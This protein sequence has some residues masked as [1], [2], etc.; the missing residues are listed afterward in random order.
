MLI[1]ISLFLWDFIL[2]ALLDQWFLCSL[3]SYYIFLHLYDAGHWG[4]PRLMLPLFFLLIQDY[5]LFGRVGLVCLYLL[6]IIFVCR[7]LRIVVMH[8]WL[9][10]IH[11][12]MIITLF[13]SEFLF[14][15]KWLF[16][17]SSGWNSTIVKISLTLA[18]TP[19]LYVVS[20]R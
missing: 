12:L 3:C 9:P 18:M 13:V 1:S 11:I 17:S 6:P 4:N 16:M 14:V 8:R 5:F 10:I 20:K 15:K 2:Y 7:L 19:L